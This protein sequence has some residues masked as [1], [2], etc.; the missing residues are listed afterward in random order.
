MV[1]SLG[2]FSRNLEDACRLASLKYGVSLR[3]LRFSVTTNRKTHSFC[4]LST[5]FSGEQ[6]FQKCADQYAVCIQMCTFGLKRTWYKDKVLGPNRQIKTCRAFHFHSEA[7]R[8]LK[9][10]YIVAHGVI[11]CLCQ[12]FIPQTNLMPTT[13]KG[14]RPFVC[15]PEWESKLE[16]CSPMQSPHPINPSQRRIQILPLTWS[17]SI[18]RRKHSYGTLSYGSNCH[19]FSMRN[20]LFQKIPSNFTPSINCM[21][22]RADSVRRCS[23]SFKWFT[24]SNQSK[25][26]NGGERLGINS[27]VCKFSFYL[28]H[29]C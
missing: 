10:F 8:L 27:A 18:A 12:Q 23:V 26:S 25:R 28:S 5:K 24:Q 19:H 11:R 21:E 29:F 17:D 2:V 6:Q 16:P 1:I 22:V 15:R 9:A 13:T 20:T 3:S 7:Q 14:G 4:C